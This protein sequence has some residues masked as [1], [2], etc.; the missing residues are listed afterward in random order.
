VAN[1]AIYAKA[2]LAF[3]NSKSNGIA[4]PVLTGEVGQAAALAP[5]KAK[6]LEEAKRLASLIL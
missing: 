6:T 5:K 3:L 1:E 4:I 2:V